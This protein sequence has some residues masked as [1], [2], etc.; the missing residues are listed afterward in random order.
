MVTGGKRLTQALAQPPLTTGPYQDLPRVLALATEIGST[1][2]LYQDIAV[3][4]Y[5]VKKPDP[6]PRAVAATSN[7]EPADAVA[8]TDDDL[9]TGVALPGSTPAGA[10][11]V[12]IDY[13]SAR[14]FRS[15]TTAGF[16][17]VTARHF[18][19]VFARDKAAD[20]SSFV[21]APGV[22]LA[23][24]VGLGGATSRPARLEK[25]RLSPDDRV[26]AFGQKAG[27]ANAD[28]YYALDASTSMG[29]T[30]RRGWPPLASLPTSATPPV[31]ATP[32]FNS[33]IANCQTATSTS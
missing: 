11:V 20:T 30:S 1:P 14:A 5:R 9:R 23:I 22:D 8:L 17:P 7:G 6:T 25:F 28:D 29:K 3:L 27:F 24:A 21:V 32:T 12:E 10:G 15:A 18:R 2:H 19:L 33:S 16:A 4:A 26:N 13:G 31:A